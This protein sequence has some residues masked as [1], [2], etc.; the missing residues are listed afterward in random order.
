MGP[1][2]HAHVQ[3]RSPSLRH[4]QTPPDPQLPAQ[5][6]HRHRDHVSDTHT[7]REDGSLCMPTPTCACEHVCPRARAK[8]TPVLSDPL[9][10]RLPVEP[11]TWVWG[12]CWCAAHSDGTQA[13]LWDTIWVPRESRPV[14]QEQE[15]QLWPGSWRAWLRPVVGTDPA[16][17]EPRVPRRCQHPLGRLCVE[18]TCTPNPPGAVTP[19]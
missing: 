13:H 2:T 4:P 17:G 1:C 19:W 8:H 14:T 12:M 6:G 15:L 5:C 9:A 16:G 7:S 11:W 10:P 18:P 3:Q